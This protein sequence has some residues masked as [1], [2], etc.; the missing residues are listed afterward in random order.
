MKDNVSN[1]FINNYRLQLWK[2]ARWYGDHSKIIDENV[3]NTNGFFIYPINISGLYCL[4][5]RSNNYIN[6]ILWDINVNDYKNN[7]SNLN[8]Y[9]LPIRYIRCTVIDYETSRQ[10][11]DAF[12]VSKGIGESRKSFLD[13]IGNVS[14]KNRNKC[15]VDKNGSIVL[16]P[17]S[18]SSQT[19][20][21]YHNNYIPGV[22]KIGRKSQE[23]YRESDAVKIDIFLKKG[24]RIYGY[25]FDDNNETVCSATISM[26]YFY[27]KQRT[28]SLPVKTNSNG[29]Y[30]SPHVPSGIVEV[31]AE[32]GLDNFTDE[33]KRINVI[34]RDVRL[35][36]CS[37]DNNIY[38][39]G[40]LYDYNNNPVVNG[41]ILLRKGTSY[42]LTLEQPYKQ[43]ATCNDKGEFVF[44][45]LF[46]GLFKVNI[47]FP[48]M[49]DVWSNWGDIFIGKS[50]NIVKD[51]HEKGSIIK[52]IIIDEN[53]NEPING[54]GYKLYMSIKPINKTK[55]TPT[56]YIKENGSFYLRCIEAGVYYFMIKGPRKLI[57]KYSNVIVYA[58]PVINEIILKVPRR[59]ILNIIINNI[60]KITKKDI[61]VE[62]INLNNN[63][64]NS[65]DWSYD[66]SWRHDSGYKIRYYVRSGYW[67]IKIN[68][69]NI[70][71]CIK[72]V[73]I[74]YDKEKS[75]VINSYELK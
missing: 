6:K 30:Q 11:E 74:N 7:Y 39:R 49:Q 21:A 28:Y 8:I 29:Y 18:N 9:L 22:T 12:L 70:G 59:C 38:W 51:I 27:N 35:D 2:G 37:R 23:K 14:N 68:I 31:H 15:L 4:Y 61:D 66:K 64:N 58:N 17:I 50:G 52:G 56:I 3:K 20:I 1:M 19:I 73:N 62:F 72:T 41:K 42:R 63:N 44:S 13:K 57:K 54:S 47:M 46:E 43:I 45:K 33:C 67:K 40:I 36:F 71:T 55:I 65:D 34:D 69:K 60:D 75:I 25:V 53:S 32:F 16:S 24:F 10:I 48:D 26:T 5:I